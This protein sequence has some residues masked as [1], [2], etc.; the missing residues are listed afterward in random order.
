MEY[1]DNRL[2]K[3]CLCKY[4]LQLPGSPGVRFRLTSLMGKGGIRMASFRS[5]VQRDVDTFTSCRKLSVMLTA[6][7]SGSGK[8]L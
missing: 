8:Y 1:T 3:S 2:K 6:G 4:A 7:R 5:A